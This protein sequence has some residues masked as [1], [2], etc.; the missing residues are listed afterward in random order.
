MR[1]LAALAII[2]G[3][4][5][6]IAP[7][8]ATTTNPNLQYYGFVAVDSHWHDPLDTEVTPIG[9]PPG[10]TNYIDEVAPFTNAN[11]MTVFGATDNVVSRLDNFAAHGSKALLDVHAVLFWNSGSG[12]PAPDPNS[13]A[14]LQP[15]TDQAQRWSS[16]VSLNQAA[17]DATHVATLYIADEPYLN[18]LTFAQLEAASDLVKASKPDLPVS[19]IEAWSALDKLRV[20]TSTDWVGFDDYVS[21]P[22][23]DP[24]YRAELALVE[25]ARSTS[26]QKIV[27]VMWAE[28]HAAGTVQ[29]YPRPPATPVTMGQVADSYYALAQSDPN[30]VAVVGYIW[31]G[32]IDGSILG[33]RDLP[34]MAKDEYIRIGHEITGKP[35]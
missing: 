7:S 15:W 29:A 13:A 26:T 11:H 24:T 27:L 28:W 3:A 5:V 16:W 19:F 20:P 22:N 14:V 34:Q 21:N 23:D 9:V 12:E 35:W 10:R 17:L 2:V 18:G 8:R 4:L 6:G 31:A 32:G 25:A 30:I 33:A 1:R